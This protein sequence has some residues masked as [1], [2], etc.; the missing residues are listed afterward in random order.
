M[1][2]KKIAHF[3]K[4]PHF[5]LANKNFSLKTTQEPS[6]TVEG[7]CIGRGRASFDKLYHV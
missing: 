4:Q 6:C 1:N 7:M 3:L 2:M 5:G